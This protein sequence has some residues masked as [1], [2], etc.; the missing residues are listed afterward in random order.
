MQSEEIRNNL[1]HLMALRIVDDREMVVDF[2][3]SRTNYEIP[4]EC[5]NEYL[6]SVLSD[7]TFDEK[8]QEKLAKLIIKDV[9]FVNFEPFSTGAILLYLAI[10]GAGATTYSSIRN[11]EE[12]RESAISGL[13]L[14]QVNYDKQI[15]EN[16]ATR[17]KEFFASILKNEQEIQ[18]Q[19]RQVLAEERKK[20]LI[21][22]VI[23]ISILTASFALVLKK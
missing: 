22:L 1:A 16:R 19:K 20:N 21:Y 15:V 9:E 8:K 17:Q 5:S 6:A 12:A 23:F 3:R 10:I 7:M 2:L 11:A 4:H 14:Q 13:T 18:E